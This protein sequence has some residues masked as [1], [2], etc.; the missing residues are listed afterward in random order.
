MNLL[1]EK[2]EHKIYGSGVIMG[3]KEKESGKKHLKVR[4]SEAKKEMDF[5]YPNAFSEHLK[6]AKKELQKQVK[7]ELCKSEEEEQR[8]KEKELQQEKLD[9]IKR[10][11]EKRENVA[12]KCNYC[13]GGKTQN[14]IGFRG[15]CSD[16]VIRSN[17]EKGCEQC[18][19]NSPCINYYDGFITRREELENKVYCYECQILKK[20]EM[21]A[22]YKR[23]GEAES[24]T[25]LQKNS[26]AVLTTREPNTREEER[27]IFGVYLVDKACQGDGENAATAAADENSP[28]RIELTPK[29]AREMLYWRY[30][31]NDKKTD[32]SWGT[33]LFR[34]LSHIQGAQILKDILQLRKGTKEEEAAQNFLE[35][36]CTI[37]GLDKDHISDPSGGLVQ[38]D[39]QA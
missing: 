15:A 25:K 4:F 8:K 28:Y 35:H 39:K 14:R 3:V 21:G 19:E 11:S 37:N 34:Y 33:K 29:E 20:W 1:N 24:I 12:F 38:R 18:C 30:Y 23:T 7:Q 13:D 5:G 2:V 22:G 9:A 31:A 36:F 17:I 16:A 26:L 10:K 27:I 32:I 6:F